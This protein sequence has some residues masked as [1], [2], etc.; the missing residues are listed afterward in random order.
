MYSVGL[1]PLCHF[2]AIILWLGRSSFFIIKFLV[3]DFQIYGKIDSLLTRFALRDT[4]IPTFKFE[5]HNQ[6]SDR[7]KPLRIIFFLRS[8]TNM[9]ILKN[10]LKWYCSCCYSQMKTIYMNTCTLYKMR[11]SQGVTSGSDLLYARLFSKCY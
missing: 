8:S 5:T 4:I 1:T 9:L 7:M 2:F 3:S 10:G 6:S 11:N